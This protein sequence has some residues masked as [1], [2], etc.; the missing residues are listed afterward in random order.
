V[1]TDL[2]GATFY[3]CNCVAGLALSAVLFFLVEQVLS[4]H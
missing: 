4:C 2:L 1:Y 3:I